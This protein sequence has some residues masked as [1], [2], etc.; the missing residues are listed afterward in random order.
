MFSLLL[1]LIVSYVD[2]FYARMAEEVCMS[3]PYGEGFAGTEDTAVRA[4]ARYETFVDDILLLPDERI[5]VVDVEVTPSVD[6]LCRLYCLSWN[7]I[8]SAKVLCWAT[9]TNQLAGCSYLRLLHEGE[10]RTRCVN[11]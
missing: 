5:V 2:P 10:D 7:C 4:T 1:S 8:Y 3:N 6:G 11:E 9:R